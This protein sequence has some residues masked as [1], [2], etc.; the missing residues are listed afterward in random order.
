MG[1]TTVPLVGAMIV[2]ATAGYFKLQ[3]WRLQERLNRPMDAQIKAVS[4]KFNGDSAV[5]IMFGCVCLPRQEISKIAV[6][7]GYRYLGEVSGSRNRFYF[8]YAQ[9]AMPAQQLCRNS[10]G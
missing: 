10:S 5:R 1:G 8:V 6:M 9:E 2:A 3:S 4:T 7:H